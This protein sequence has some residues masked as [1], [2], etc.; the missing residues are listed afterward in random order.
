MADRNGSRLPPARRDGLLVQ[1]IDDEVQV[2]DTE[3]HQ[4]HCLNRTAARVWAH[5][6]G[7]T[8]VAT[9]TRRLR[10]EFET[11]VDPQVVWLAVEQLSKARLLTEV[12]Q[13]PTASPAAT[14]SSGWGWRRPWPCRW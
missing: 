5:C 2:Y 8:S 14:C 3:R 4:A 6:D 7:Q 11:P 13:L 9:L 10:Q 12:P 1:A